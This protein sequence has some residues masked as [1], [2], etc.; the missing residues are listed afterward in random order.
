MKN[1]S[2]KRWMITLLVILATAAGYF[3][4]RRYGGNSPRNPLVWQYLS[5]PRSHKD[6]EV[7][8]GEK[9]A[10]SP[11]TF[12]T[13]GFIGYLW[14]D[15]FKAGHPHQGLD[16]FGGAEPGV[17]PVYAVYDGYLS[18]LDGWKSS[19]ILRIPEDPLDAQRQIW[20]YYTHMADPS[21]KSFISPDFPAGTGEVFIKR[22]TLLGYQGNY[23]G[24]PGNPV[25]VHLHLSIVRDDGYGKFKNE[26]EIK[27][28]YD[29][30]PYFGLPLSLDAG[31]TQIL[32]CGS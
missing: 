11:F 28:T 27:N 14:G 26:L 3:L 5:S 31:G 16:F 25:G 13:A 8:A 29:P 32:T 6:W 15:T 1:S 24:D 22:G 2:S 9:C 10:G 4:Y 20:V 30:S 23:S 7:Q 12:P 17:T 21:G 18:R 19:L